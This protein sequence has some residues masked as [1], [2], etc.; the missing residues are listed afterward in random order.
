MTVCSL[1]GVGV[2]CVL[3]PV[4]EEFLVLLQDQELTQHN[5]G[6]IEAFAGESLTQH[7]SDAGQ[8]RHFLLPHGLS[9]KVTVLL[10]GGRHA[11]AL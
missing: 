11:A 4:N 9:H 10:A 5:M 7:R 2:G 8:L 6:L 3:Q 1:L